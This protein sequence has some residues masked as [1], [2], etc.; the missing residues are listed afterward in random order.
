LCKIKEFRRIATRY[1]KTDQSFK[2]MIHRVGIVL[3]TRSMS[4]GPSSSATETLTQMP[5]GPHGTASPWA[6]AVC[7]S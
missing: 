5:G 3:A 7:L 6:Q 1:D 4:T 2:A